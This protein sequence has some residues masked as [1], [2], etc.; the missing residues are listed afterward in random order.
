[1]VGA[2]H[3]ETSMKLIAIAG[4]FAL[5]L[6]GASPAFAGP[7]DCTSPDTDLDTVIDCQ[8]NCSD[9]PN[10]SQ[11]DGDGDDCG[12]RCDADFDQSGAVVGF[13][14]FGK[15]GANF[16]T[17]SATF[18]LDEPPTPPVG[19]SDFGRFG[20]LFNSSPGPSGTTPGRTTCP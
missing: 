5:L 3:E 19:F 7:G 13:A 12:N 16:N 17:V 18:E 4:A 8:D 10:L 2:T 20:A 15:F 14:D 9:D 6:F 1:M 11:T